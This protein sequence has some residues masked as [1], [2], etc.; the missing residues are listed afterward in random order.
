MSTP[1]PFLPKH[2][3]HFG[4]DSGVECIGRGGVCGFVHVT[5]YLLRQTDVVNVTMLLNVV[6]K[7]VRPIVNTCL[8]LDTI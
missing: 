2:G 4:A 7:Y 6:R 5:Y 8:Q 1:P 3:K